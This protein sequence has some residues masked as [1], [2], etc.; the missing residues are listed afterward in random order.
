MFI[1]DDEDSLFPLNVGQYYA[2]KLITEY[3]RREKIYIGQF[4]QRTEDQ[5]EFKFLR[6]KRPHSPVFSFPEKDD[7]ARFNADS[8]LRKMVLL[9][10]RRGPFTFEHVPDA[11]L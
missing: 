2:V 10:E 3:D 7:I 6:K 1:S 9:I 11:Y 4:L 5:Y 8:I